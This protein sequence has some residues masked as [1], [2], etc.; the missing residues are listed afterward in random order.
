MMRDHGEEQVGTATRGSSRC[1]SRDLHPEVQ[2][3]R[4]A[5][6]ICAQAQMLAIMAT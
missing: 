6:M 1:E 3:E 5:M 4:M 2:W